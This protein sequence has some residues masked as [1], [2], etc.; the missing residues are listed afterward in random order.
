MSFILGF[1]AGVVASGLALFLFMVLEKQAEL[2]G[3]SVLTDA[4]VAEGLLERVGNDWIYHGRDYPA[5]KKWLPKNVL[6][7]AKK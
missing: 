3:K 5:L 2:R 7:E 4:L 1:I 6:Y